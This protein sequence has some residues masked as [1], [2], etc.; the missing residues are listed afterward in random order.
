MSPSNADNPSLSTATASARGQ[1]V[2]GEGRGDVPASEAREEAIRLQ[3]EALARSTLPPPEAD[4]PEDLSTPALTLPINPRKRRRKFACKRA[5]K[6]KL[7]KKALNETGASQDTLSQVLSHG[8][9]VEVDLDASELEAARGAHTGK[10]GKKENLG[11]QAE[12]ERQYSLEELLAQG[13]EHIEWDGRT[14]IPIVDRSGRIIA[15]LAGQPGSD[16]EQDLLEAFKLFS[17]AGEEAGLGQTAAG[18]RHKR[19]SFPAFNR[20]VTMGMGS[21]TPVALNPGLMSGILDRLVGAK[22]VRRM[23]AYQ[24]GGF[25][26][27]FSL[28]APRVHDEYKNAQNALRGR[29]PHLPD[30]FPGISDFAA[31]AFN[32]GGK[33]WTFKH[34]DFLNWPFGWCAITALGAFDPRRTAQLIL[35]ELKLVLNFPHGAT[36]LIPSGVITHSNTPVATG[37][38]RMSFTQYTAGAIFRWVENGCRTEKELQAADP[39]CW[40][41]MQAGKDSAY[42]RRIHNFSTIEELMSRIQ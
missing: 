42:I 5:Q 33:V 6:R 9:A 26:P 13:F 37:D 23:A 18:G 8:T 38:T 25:L 15:V 40:A 14:P 32:L 22:A 21:P 41:G 2:P 34:R 11:S 29:F 31:A 19:G 17:E 4:V 20:G 39:Q 28:W 24:N 7:E 12:R 16:Y 27:A 3:P 30:N 36:V 35:W 10:P 1:I